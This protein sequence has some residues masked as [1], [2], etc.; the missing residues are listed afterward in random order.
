MAT[1]V[2]LQMQV[3][4]LDLKAQYAT[5][6]EEVQAAI[7]QVLE[8]QHFILGPEVKA[9]EQEIAHYCGCKYGIGVASGTDALILG[10][11][12]CGIG[13]G[14]EVLV[15][16]FTF[17]ATADAVSALGATPVFVDIEPDTF[18]IDSSRIEPLIT[19]R[20]R[21]IVP[22]HLYGQM[23]AMGPLLKLAKD[24]N[25][26]VV[27]DTAQ[28]LGATW[29]GRRAA[30][31]GDVGCISFFPSKN[32]GAYGDGGMVV[33]D[34]E[35][36]YRHLIS[37]RAHGSTKKYFSQEQGWNSRLDELQAAIL[38][39][40]FRHL[41]HWSQQRRD[42][43]DRY[44]TLL[45][46]VRGVVV[47]ARNGSGQ[48]VF[49]QYTIRVPQR[50]RVQKQLAEQGVTTMVYYPVPIHLQPIYASLGHRP[51]SLPLT[52]AACGEVLSLPMFPELTEQQMEYVVD[53]L[54]LALNE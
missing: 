47:P 51:G 15:P 22:V 10:L 24:H 26:K 8:K 21:A 42:V 53:M 5:I 48:H 11:R 14:D 12:A 9:L 6:R 16:S 3:P 37:L 36:I 19:A 7:N 32:L 27:E 54:T 34:S 29:E 52:E 28:A 31:L 33:T 4:I 30:S 46:G 41:E 45:S 13:P 17:I 1:A 43:A 40:K 18:N 23:A 44:D 39:V 2:K 20:T 50:D 35:E 38:R 49:H 25:L